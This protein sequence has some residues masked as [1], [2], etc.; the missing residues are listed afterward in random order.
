MN[1]DALQE[2]INA[3]EARIT[4]IDKMLASTQQTVVS[5]ELLRAELRAVRAELASVNR[6]VG[7]LADE[8]ATVRSEG[9][10]L[11]LVVY[12]SALTAVGAVIVQII[13]G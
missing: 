6:A 2:R 12:A 4:V 11:R 9:F 8:N 13:G 1:E 10:R 3:L 7:D 5:K